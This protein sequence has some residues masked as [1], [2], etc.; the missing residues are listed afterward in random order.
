M[1]KVSKAQAAVKDDTTGVEVGDIPG[2]D[3][4]LEWYGKNTPTGEEWEGKVIHGDFKCDNMVSRMTQNLLQCCILILAPSADLSS[5]QTGGDWRARLGV[6]DT[7][8]L[9]DVAMVLRS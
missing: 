5:H 6:V 9:R 7:G 2:V 1:T 4:L 8:T 3:F